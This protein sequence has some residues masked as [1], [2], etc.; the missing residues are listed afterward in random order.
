MPSCSITRHLFRTNAPIGE[1]WCD[2]SSVLT[3]RMWVVRLNTSESW[4]CSPRNPHWHWHEMGGC[5]GREI[6]RGSAK[7]ASRTVMNHTRPVRTDKTG[8]LDCSG[9]DFICQ[10][11]TNGL[12]HSGEECKALVFL[13]SI[14]HWAIRQQMTERRANGAQVCVL[15]VA[16]V[17]G[18]WAHVNQLWNTGVHAQYS[19][20]M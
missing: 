14:V 20:G 10:K 19:T 7:I 1:I 3:G 11:D 12:N 15:G 9:L 2:P 6:E 16:Q 8:G 18:E 4:P 5:A 17:S 13:R